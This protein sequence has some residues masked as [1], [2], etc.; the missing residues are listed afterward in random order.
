MDNNAW[1]KN[2]HKFTSFSLDQGDAYT[3]NIIIICF[4]IDCILILWSLFSSDFLEIIIIEKLAI[5][6]EVSAFCWVSYIFD[7]FEFRFLH[8]SCVFVYPSLAY[9]RNFTPFIYTI[10]LKIIVRRVFFLFWNLKYEMEIVIHNEYDAH[11]REHSIK[12]SILCKGSV[13]CNRGYNTSQFSY[14]F[15]S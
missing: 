2:P 5:S 7:F 15:F 9:F 3:P 11:R 13:F 14:R 6:W 10:Q 1:I 12:V 4:P 8:H